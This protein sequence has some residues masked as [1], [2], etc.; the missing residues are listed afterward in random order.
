MCAPGHESG[1]KNN[2]FTHGRTSEKAVPVEFVPIFFV[3]KDQE[4]NWGDMKVKGMS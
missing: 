3:Y 2:F 1:Q 4:M